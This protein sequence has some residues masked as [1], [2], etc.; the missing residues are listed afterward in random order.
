[1]N[2]EIITEAAQFLFGEYINRIFFA[3]HY[4]LVFYNDPCTS[5][6]SV[7]RSTRVN[8][9]DTRISLEGEDYRKQSSGD[10]ALREKY[11]QNAR[12]M[13]A[14]P[15]PGRLAGARNTMQKN[16]INYN[17]LILSCF[18]ISSFCFQDLQR[19]RMHTGWQQ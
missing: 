3:M 15:S 7:E 13:A 10:S 12:F 9:S 18:F 1:M 16:C 5:A 14:S 2:V 8:H 17:R 11:T 6:A 4:K 19:L